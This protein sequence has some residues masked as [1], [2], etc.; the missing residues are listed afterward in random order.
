MLR[1][2]RVLAQM[3]PIY[4]NPSPIDYSYDPKGDVLYV[5][6]ARQKAV[7]TFELLTD[8]PMVM[9]DVNKKDQIIGVEYVGVKQFGV[10]TFMRLLQERVRRLG[11][12]IAEKEAESFLSFMRTPEAEIALA[13]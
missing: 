8:W 5:T 11:I 6:F 7:R 1:Y 10:E 13:N 9:V 3:K 2:H 12:E 4:A